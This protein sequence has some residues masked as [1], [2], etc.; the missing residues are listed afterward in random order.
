[1]QLLS[2]HVRL[3]VTVVGSRSAH[4]RE[5]IAMRRKLRVKIDPIW[6]IFLY[7]LEFFSQQ[8]GPME[9]LPESQLRYT[10]GFLGLGRIPIDILGVPLAQ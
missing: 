6:A 9:P 1:V 2:N 8:I 3:L 7:A 5:V 4:T 10:T